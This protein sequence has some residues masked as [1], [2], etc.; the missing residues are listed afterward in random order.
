MKLAVMML[1]KS[2][3]LPMF[4]HDPKH[5]VPRMLLIGWAEQLSIL[6]VLTVASLWLWFGLLEP[7][8]RDVPVPVVR[9]PRAV[10]VNYLESS[11]PLRLGDT[12]FVCG[13]RGIGA[14]TIA[15][16]PRQSILN[17]DGSEPLSFIILGTGQYYVAAPDGSGQAFARNHIRGI[18]Q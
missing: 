3:E 5:K 8:F 11:A 1:R 7:I 12:V 6:L 2:N 17:R 18:V 4:L 16:L 14:G 9:V 15:A 13:K 10:Q